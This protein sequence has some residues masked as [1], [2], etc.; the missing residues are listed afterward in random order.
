MSKLLAWRRTLIASAAIAVA[1]LGALAW[2]SHLAK[3]RILAALGP[4]AT[5]GAIT[6]GWP[7]VTLHDVHVAADTTP[8]AW[9]SPDEFRAALVAVRVDV[10]S[11]WAYRGGGALRIA[12]M[13]VEDGALVML[14]THGHVTMLPALRETTRAEAAAI[15]ASAGASKPVAIDPQSSEPTPPATALVVAHAHVERLA[16]DLYDAT[17]GPGAPQRLQFA[18]VHGDVDDIALPT[19]DTSIAVDAAGT[20]KGVERDGSISVRGS[21]TPATHDAQLALRLAGV[22]LIAL[23]PWLLRLGEGSVKHGSLDLQLDAKVAHRELEAPGRITLSGLQLAD[24]GGTFAQAKRRAVLAALERDGRVDIAFTL[25]GRTDDPKFSLNDS[26]VARIAGGVAQS[27][28]DSVKSA[29]SGIGGAIK[30]LFG[31]GDK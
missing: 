20:L 11:L 28:T 5:V 21:F 30:G 22:D 25:Q 18:Q 9:P 6:L 1:V 8:G 4:R 2:A 24:E 29:V 23:Q 19:L 7:S 17:L 31:K 3:T 10:A 13:R 27:T 15:A 26:L 16:V 12:D 14:R